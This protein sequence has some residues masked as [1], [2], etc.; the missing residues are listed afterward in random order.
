MR[1]IGARARR[2]PGGAVSRA[3]CQALAK[4]VDPRAGRVEQ[5]HLA[6]M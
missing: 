5:Q 4:I 6:E 1:A 3:V 2:R